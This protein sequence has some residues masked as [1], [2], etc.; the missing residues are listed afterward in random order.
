MVMWGHGRNAK[1]YR[2]TE[3]VHQPD[4]FHGCVHMESQTAPLLPP[5][6]QPPPA[7]W[8]CLNKTR[9]SCVWTVTFPEW[10]EQDRKSPLSEPELLSCFEDFLASRHGGP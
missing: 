7:S 5:R 1:S 10:G 2:P 3:R 9:A 8:P 4:S 6:P